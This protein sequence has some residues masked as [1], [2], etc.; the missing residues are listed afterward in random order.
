MTNTQN[1]TNATSKSV[2]SAGQGDDDET[3]DLD[4]CCMCFGRYE[5]D[6]LEGLGAEWIYC[7]S[8]A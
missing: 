4:T 3:I 7:R 5:D 6:V 1:V 8:G 2:D